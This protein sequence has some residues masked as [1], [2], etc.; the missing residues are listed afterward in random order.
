[1]VIDEPMR[2]KAPTNYA[3][4]LNGCPIVRPVN[5]IIILNGRKTTDKKRDW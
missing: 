4:G 3:Y 2:E 1:M 5:G